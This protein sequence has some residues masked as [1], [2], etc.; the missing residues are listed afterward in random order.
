MKESKNQVSAMVITDTAESAKYEQINA[1]TWVVYY[2]LLSISNYNNEEKDHRFVYRKDFNITKVSKA[3]GVGRATFYRALDT[4]KANH[5]IVA[6]A[7]GNYFTIPIRIGW[8]RVSKNLLNELLGYSSILGVDLLR[9]YL[10]IKALY[11]VGNT[12]GFTRRNL[13]RCLGHNEKD[14]IYYQKV[15]IYLA[16]LERWELVYLDASTKVDDFG[17]FIVYFIQNVRDSSKYLDNNLEIRL[18]E[19]QNP[20]GLTQKEE[21]ELKTLF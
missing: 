10:F 1:K 3:L 12:S 20:Y 16:L 6:S 17:G 18:R 11:E 7:S 13:I 4:L 2:Y 21:E 15:E 9:T 8:A 19:Q 5:L 14:Q